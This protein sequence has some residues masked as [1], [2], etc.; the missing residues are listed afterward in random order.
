MKPLISIAVAVALSSVS[1]T[2]AGAGEVCLACLRVRLDPPQVVRG[3]YPD[4][5]DNAFAALHLKDGRWRGFSA[6]GATYAIDGATLTDMSGRRRAVLE[7][8]PKGSASECGRWL[9]SVLPV[10]D[11]VYGLVHQESGCDYGHGQTHKSMAMALSRDQGLTW[12]V[13][14]D[15]ITG[16]DAARPGATT[17]EGDC[18]MVDGQDG[19]AYAYCLRNSDSRTIAARA[20]LADPGPGNW[21]KFADGRWDT[22]ALGGEAS[23]I[24]FYGVASAYLKN[25]DR[26]ALLVGD[27]WFGGLRLSLSADKS[28][29]VDLKEPLLPID[30]ADWNRPAPTS[31]IAYVSALDPANGSNVVGNDFFLAM[32]YIPPGD[33]FAHRYLVLQRVH[34]DLQPKPLS[35]Q[36]GIALSRWQSKDGRS[37]ASTGPIVD[38]NFAIARRLGY[39]MT[40]PPEG[41]ASINLEECT[42]GSAYRLDTDG[43]CAKLGLTR[44]RTAGWAYDTRQPDTLALYRCRAADGTAFVSNE[45]ECESKGTV[46][47]RLGFALAQ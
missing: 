40:K 4:E 39:L 14:G 42:D 22:D 19:Y 24:G 26:V 9:N 13:L 35:P 25:L 10:G 23:A 32:V 36:V 41:T 34:L 6:N 46:E 15:V 2:T 47:I 1:L 30:A 31:L 3:P 21:K 20:P 37:R 33:T 27:Q 7:P 18:T 5:L 45:P 17:G 43:S 16:P 12:S 44:L 11:V 8:G 38:H 29:F 28:H